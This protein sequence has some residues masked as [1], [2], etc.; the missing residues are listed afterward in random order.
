M[1]KALPGSHTAKYMGC[2]CD[3][4]QNQ[5]GLGV[6]TPMGT[7][8]FVISP[9]CPV[10]EHGTTYYDEPSSSVAIKRHGLLPQGNSVLRNAS[11]SRTWREVL[12]KG[13]SIMDGNSSRLS[14]DSKSNRNLD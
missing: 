3:M 7:R 2:T 6:G 1:G 14:R 8:M 12:F 11:A 5:F 10:H 9:E 4:I 13:N